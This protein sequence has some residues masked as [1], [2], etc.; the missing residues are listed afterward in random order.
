MAHS[1]N[2]EERLQRHDQAGEGGLLQRAVAVGDGAGLARHALDR[3][4]RDEAHA[5]GPEIGFGP[6]LDR[7]DQAALVLRDDVGAEDEV[8]VSG[9]DAP[10]VADTKAALSLLDLQVRDLRRVGFPARA[11]H[12]EGKAAQGFRA[13][14]ADPAEL[15]GV[16]RGRE[17]TGAERPRRRHLIFRAIEPERLR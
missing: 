11:A 6:K 8:A 12:D 5:A 3:M 2:I 16:E 14:E 1:G 7:E 4:E 9:V 13:A 17:C 10:V 15:A